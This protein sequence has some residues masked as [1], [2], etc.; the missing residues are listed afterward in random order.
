VC[1]TSVKAQLMKT[2]LYS[3]GDVLSRNVCWDSATRLSV[4][5]F[6]KFKYIDLVFGGKYMQSMNERFSII[7]LLS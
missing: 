4:I 5:K 1:V 7:C 2:S 6:V 3:L